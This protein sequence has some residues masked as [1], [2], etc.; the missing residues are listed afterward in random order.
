MKLKHVPDIQEQV[1]HSFK[2]EESY[3]SMIDSYTSYVS[4]NIGKKISK[5]DVI[6]SMIKTFLDED[7]KFQAWLKVRQKQKSEENNNQQNLPNT[8]D[9]PITQSF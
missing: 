1:K 3:S 5:D 6:S 4:E 7:K 2:V 9:V 8:E